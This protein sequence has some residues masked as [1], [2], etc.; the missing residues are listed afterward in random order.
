M[1]DRSIRLKPMKERQWVEGG[2]SSMDLSEGE[3]DL[4]G[5]ELNLVG[6]M[7]NVA[8]SKTNIVGFK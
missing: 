3:K 4:V 6:S 2:R 8:R 5:F 7:P 1:D